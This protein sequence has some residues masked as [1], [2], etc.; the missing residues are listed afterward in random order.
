MGGG[1]LP[2]AQGARAP[3]Q[4]KRRHRAGR[5]I[6]LPAQS[7]RRKLCVGER[8]RAP[9]LAATDDIDK[10]EE[11]T[12]AAATVLRLALPPPRRA[13]P[14]GVPQPTQV[15]QRRTDCARHP[16]CPTHLGAEEGELASLL[17]LERVHRGLYYG[18]LGGAAAAA[19][20]ATAAAAAAT[21]AAAAAAGHR[22]ADGL[23]ARRGAGSTSSTQ[24]DL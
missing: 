16:G 11:A 4:P 19:A 7:A 18:L 1:C 8:Q 15:R 17:L 3:G 21:A 6:G 22:C 5:A 10:H 13:R 9:A 24:L 14:L 12:N 23:L 20:A 2:A